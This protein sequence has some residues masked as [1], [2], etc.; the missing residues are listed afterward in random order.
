MAYYSGQCNSYQHLAE[1]LVEKCQAH[2]W[3][4]RDEI[5][6]KDNV[7]IKL[8]VCNTPRSYQ[9][10]EGI[11]LSAMSDGLLADIQP[12]LGGFGTINE[13]IFPALYHLFVFGQEVYL[14]LKVG[15]DKFYHLAFGKSSILGTVWVSATSPQYCYADQWISIATNGGGAS[16]SSITSSAPFWG[17]AY[18][19]PNW[20]HCTIQHN[21]DGYIWSGHSSQAYC[22]FEPLISRLPTTHFSDSPL[23]PYNIY[24]ERPE[25]K[26]S[27]IC[28]FENA[29]FVR[30]DNYENE[31]ILTL[32]HERWMVFPFYRKNVVER[33]GGHNIRHTGTF[34]WAIRYEG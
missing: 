23:L 19:N 4:W 30:V 16:S 1:I 20:C 9:T 29:R 27:L 12:R 31:Q 2:G 17:G 28:Q 15:V 11:I 6:S 32:G 26:L 7:A 8:W 25:N 18:H 33:N 22:N 24:L 3:A 13:D 34:G 10:G 14:V 21:L 5:L